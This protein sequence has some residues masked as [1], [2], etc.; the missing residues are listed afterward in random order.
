MVSKVLLELDIHEGLLDSIDIEWRGHHTRQK[1]DY[2]GI[3]FRCT[4]C[5][6]TGH[7]RKHFPGFAE[8]EQSEDN[9]LELSSSMDSLG[10]NTHATYPDLFDAEDPTTL[11]SI[12]GK[13]KQ[14]CP[15]LFFTLT[16]WEIEQLDNSTFLA[17]GSPTFIP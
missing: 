13:L 2:L 17:L 12:T 10:V 5:R 3:P 11:D 9:V 16:V 6:Q 7:L 8:E 15:T 1:L 4:L 14:I